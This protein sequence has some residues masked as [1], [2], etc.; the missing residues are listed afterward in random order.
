LTFLLSDKSIFY[1]GGN[2]QFGFRRAEL[3]PAIDGNGNA[4]DVSG[5]TTF[6]WSMRT[7]PTRPLNYTHEYHVS[8]HVYSSH[9]ISTVLTACSQPVWHEY[10]D[11]SSSQFTITLG[12]PFDKGKDPNVKEAKS[13][14][15]AGLQALDPEVTFFETPFTDNVW[16][17]FALTLDWVQKYVW[18]L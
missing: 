12:T 5:V 1:P 7:D 2:P 15:V 17:N 8:L 18:L 10:A 13:I 9:F 6:H 11:Y 16:H 14:R 4:S 3:M